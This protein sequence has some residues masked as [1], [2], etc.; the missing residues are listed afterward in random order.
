[1]IPAPSPARGRPSFL[2]EAR[3][4]PELLMRISR[5]CISHSFFTDSRGIGPLA[6]ISTRSSAFTLPTVMSGCAEKAFWPKAAISSLPI[7]SPASWFCQVAS[8]RSQPDLHT[9]KTTH[10]KSC[11]YITCGSGC[12][13][14]RDYLTVPNVSG[15]GAPGRCSLTPA[16][17]A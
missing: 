1:M 16:I 12:P 11:I 14:K 8:L 2:H 17:T 5:C 13:A 15:P 10:T 7:P 4:A 6:G 3:Y 9:G